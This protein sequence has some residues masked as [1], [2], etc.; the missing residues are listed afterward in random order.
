MFNK[1]CINRGFVKRRFNSQLIEMPVHSPSIEHNYSDS[2]YHSMELNQYTQEKVEKQKELIQREEDRKAENER[3]AKE[4]E[5]LNQ[6][7]LK[8]IEDN[9]AR[10]A[11]EEKKK[12]EP[13]AMDI[14][15][16]PDELL[17]P[18]VV[19]TQEDIKPIKQKEP[20]V[21]NQRLFYT[22]IINH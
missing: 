6:A 22:Q 11:A 1:G 18:P 3:I 12:H 17:P 19:H 5:H 9:K 10:L 13:Q 7:R 15:N 4:T 20:N 14:D 8:A 21:T 16:V 2:L